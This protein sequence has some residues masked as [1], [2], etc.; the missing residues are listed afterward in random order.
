MP[1]ATSRKGFAL[2]RRPIVT[3]A[4][5][6]LPVFALFALF[7]AAPLI[8]L[9]D[10]SLLS[11]QPSAQRPNPQYSFVNYLKILSDP[12]YL[13]VTVNSLVVGF[14]TTIATLAISY[15]LAYYITKI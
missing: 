2:S 12:F 5:L 13:Q 6:L 10:L 3:A 15:P 4:L 14:S 1:E 9:F 7:F 8:Q 11:Q